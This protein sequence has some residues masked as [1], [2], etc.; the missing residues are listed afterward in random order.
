MQ[1]S[2]DGKRR[3]DEAKGREYVCISKTR[4]KNMF[5]NQRIKQGKRT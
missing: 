3:K 4:K 1:A 5:K 2:R